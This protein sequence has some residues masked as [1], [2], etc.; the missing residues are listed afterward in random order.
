MSRID[1]IPRWK[2]LYK[3]AQKADDR[4]QAALVKE[5]GSRAGDMRYR[6]DKQT[7]AIRKLGAAYRKKSIELSKMN[8]YYRTHTENPKRSRN[9]GTTVPAHVRIN[10]R[11]G[12]IQVFV[13]PKVAEKL[14]GGKG[15]R[16]AG[17]SNPT[18]YEIYNSKTKDTMG[19]EFPTKKEADK[20]IKYLQSGTGLKLWWKSRRKK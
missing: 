4:F 8:E 6:N 1:D 13:T 5:Y 15:L 7:P 16:V 20:F 11:N 3:A 12:R 17:A 18:T 14:R 9:T 10:P 19:R 2:K